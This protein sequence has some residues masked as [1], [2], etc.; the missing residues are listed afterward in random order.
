MARDKAEIINPPSQALV[1]LILLIAGLTGF[2]LGWLHPNW[3]LAVEGG[4]IV[5]N[6]VVYPEKLP[7]YQYYVNLW[8]IL[9]QFCA[10]FLRLGII[11]I[12]SVW[13]GLCFKKIR[14]PQIGANT[15]GFTE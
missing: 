1:P 7:L 5:G 6:L 15:L 3:Q 11:E 9:N 10:L 8:T 2:V 14:I 12:K 13:G 4:Q